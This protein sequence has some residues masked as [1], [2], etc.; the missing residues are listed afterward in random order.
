MVR[1]QGPGVRGQGLSRLWPLSSPAPTTRPARLVFLLQDLKFGGT[2]RQVLELAR[3]LD[4]AR[5]QVEIWLLAAGDDLAALARDWG[6]PL[7]RLSRQEQV[8]PRALLHLWRHLRRAEIDL[9][10]PF[11]VVP[12]IWGRVLGR[13]ARVPLIVGNCRGGGAPR[14]QHEAWLWPL[15]HH[16]LCNSQAVKSVLRERCRVPEARLTVI[17]NGVDTDYFQTAAGP[18]AGPPRVLSVARMVPDK[19]HHTLLQAFRLTVQVNP[20]AELWLVGDGPRLAEVREWARRLLPPAR[21]KFLSPREDLRPLL[22][23]ASLLALS[24]KTEALPNVILEAMAA[25]LPVVATR[26]GGVPELV[27]PGLTGW[28][29]APGD[30]LGL[31]AALGQVLGDPDTRQAMGRAGRQRAEKEFSLKT[32]TRQYEAV[33]DRL[34]AQAGL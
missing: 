5:F 4:P 11:T 13:M 25:G 20:E 14:R 28:L 16:I 10:M 27:V 7:M 29:V 21:V 32:M 1:G 23:Q 17:P 6:L 30:A 34:L 12:N 26:V 8:G 2:Q 18:E 19:D 15:A 3:R 33:L 24:S 31:A 22:R 9:L